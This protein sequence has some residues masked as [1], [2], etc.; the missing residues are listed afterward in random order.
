ME[1]DVFISRFGKPAETLAK[2]GSG[3]R[4]IR[5]RSDPTT[6]IRSPRLRTTITAMRWNSWPR[7]SPPRNPLQAN[8][9]YLQGA[10][11]LCLNRYDEALARSSAPTAW[12]LAARTGVR[13]D[14]CRPT[15]FRR[16]AQGAGVTD[17]QRDGRDGFAPECRRPCLPAGPGPLE[18]GRR[19]AGQAAHVAGKRFA[20]PGGSL[21]T[22]RDSRWTPMSATVE[23]ARPAPVY[24]RPVP[25][26]GW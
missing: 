16:G 12:A 13:R 15:R 11:L 20:R 10:I 17:S 4:C 24:R 9:Y 8:A 5:T 14:P 6:C 1:L 22:R 19:I 23:R 25:A 2:A 26:L 3:H 18:G 21:W 7:P